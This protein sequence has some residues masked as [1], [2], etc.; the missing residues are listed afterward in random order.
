MKPVDVLKRTLP[1]VV[2]AAILAYLF[3]RIDLAA[4][5]ATLTAESASILIP[6]ILI[7]GFVSLA[8]EGVSLARLTDSAGRP[9]SVSTCSPRGCIT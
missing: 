5:F 2:T 7:Y 8:I 4:A 3:D 6:A 1:F 9:A